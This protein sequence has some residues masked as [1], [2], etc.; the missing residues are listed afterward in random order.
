MKFLFLLW[1]CVAI[2]GCGAFYVPGTEDIPL[3]GGLSS[4]EFESPT[5]FD[6]PQGRVV[7]SKLM[8]PLKRENIESFY[9]EALVNLGWRDLGNN[10]Y[11]REDQSLVIKTRSFESGTLIWFELTESSKSQ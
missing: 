3:M 10:T 8:S 6:T 5:L 4:G 7:I 1:A 11:K 9:S 2:N